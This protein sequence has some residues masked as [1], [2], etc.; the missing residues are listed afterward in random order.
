MVGRYSWVYRLI[1]SDP[2]FAPVALCASGTLEEAVARKQRNPKDVVANIRL[3]LEHMPK[4]SFKRKLRS[5]GHL[6]GYE[7]WSP[8][9]KEHI[10]Q[11]CSEGQIVVMPALSQVEADDWVRFGLADP[12]PLASTAETPQPDFFDYL[13]SLRLDSEREVELHFASPLFRHLGYDEN[14]EA[15]GFRFEKWDGA[16]REMREADLLYFADE[17]HDLKHGQPLVLVEC[18]APSEPAEAGFGEAQ[19]YAYWLKPAYYVVTNGDALTVYLYQGT[20]P[21]PRKHATRRAQLHADFDELRHILNPAAAVATRRQTQ[22]MFDQN[23][24]L[25]PAQGGESAN[26]DN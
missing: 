5:L 24:S 6:F 19:S 18:K 21:D 12:P 23:P 16:K 4:H 2:P 25:D 7:R 26:V 11:L 20:V 22:A 17:T 13:A 15:A 8:Q 9:E 1:S 3:T 14:Q 10:E